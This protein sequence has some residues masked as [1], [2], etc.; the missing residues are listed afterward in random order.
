MAKGVKGSTPVGLEAKARTSIIST[1]G[2]LEKIRYIAFM[3]KE[4]MSDLVNA[5]FD[6]IIAKYEKDNGPIPVK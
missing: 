6:K 1:Y 3:Q 2:R 5:A 4:D